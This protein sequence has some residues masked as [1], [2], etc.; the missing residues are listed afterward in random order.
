MSDVLHTEQ[1]DRVALIRLNRP[2]ARNAMNAE[3]AQATV[4]AIASSQ[5]AGA[6]VITG[7]GPAFCAGLDLR[8]LGVDQLVDLPHFTRAVHESEIP[9]IAAV[10]GPAVTGGFELALACDF[11][12]GSPRARFADTH[13]IVGVYPG[14]VLVDLP[15]R[16]G[17]A[18]AREMSLTGRFIDADT[19]LRIGL[20]NHVVPEANLVP[21]ALELAGEIASRDSKMVRAMREDW[22]RTS[23]L[24]LEEAHRSHL[25]FAEQAGFA[26]SRGE[27]IAANRGAVLA[28]AHEQLD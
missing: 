23:G 2:D 6:I 27:E 3:L 21:F 24:G 11:M 4:D 12:I 25:A 18:F 20:L 1:H 7:E 15:R 14:P 13:L 9:I 16:V 17:P 26:G 28:R 5:D 22:R 19:A 10:N 8:A